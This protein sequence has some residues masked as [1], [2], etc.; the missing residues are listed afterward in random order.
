L[1]IKEGVETL[2]EGTQTISQDKSDKRQPLY[3]LT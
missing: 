1:N 2:I 3:Q